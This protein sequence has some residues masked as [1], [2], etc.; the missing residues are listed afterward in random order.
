MKGM[1]TKTLYEIAEP[2]LNRCR[3]TIEEIRGDDTKHKGNFKQEILFAVALICIEARKDNW[4]C[5]AIGRF[6]NRDHS[7]VV[8]HWRERQ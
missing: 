6:L 7:T 5:Q 8:K 3:V 1:P 4:G 2:I